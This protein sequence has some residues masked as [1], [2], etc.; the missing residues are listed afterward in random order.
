[1]RSSVRLW[2]VLV[3]VAMTVGLV[4]SVA[5][6]DDGP[7]QVIFM[8]HS[9]GAGIMYGGNVREALTDLGY[10]F[11]DHGYNDEGLTDADGNWAGLSY[12]VPG[13]NTDPDGWYEIFN[14]V[15]T[16]PPTNTLS[17][18]LTY[19]VIIFKS[20][21]PSSHIDSE[22]MFE[23]Y[24]TYYLS[25]RDVIDRYPDKLFI[26]WTT[27]PLV[28]NSTDAESAARADRWANY[29]TSDEYLD[30]HPNI[31]VFDIFHILADEDGFLAAPYRVDEWDSHPNDVAN[32]MAGTLF[33][34]FIDS[35][36]QAFA[37]G[38]PIAPVT[39]PVPAE[40]A[41]DA[42]DDTAVDEPPET[43]SMEAVEAGPLLD[44]FESGEL[45]YDWWSHADPGGTLDCVVETPGYDGFYGLALRYD[46][47][48]DVYAGCGRG[49]EGGELW[50]EAAGLQFTWRSEFPDQPFAVLLTVDSTPFEAILTTPGQ[51]W[52]HITLAWSDFERAEWADVGGPQAVEPESVVDVAFVLG[53][54]ESAQAGTVWID[55][56]SLIVEAGEGESISLRPF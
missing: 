24:Q 15:Y 4:S 35:A 19:D 12:D 5:A 46:L 34:E 2:V 36:Y 23:D 29:L 26:L 39:T 51:D 32:E 25:I 53:D 54:W 9:T 17:H 52:S 18:M 48:V 28:P 30:G 42:G 13:D 31:A 43:E 16:D 47:P 49:V 56:L 3:V 45:S 50:A 40:A 14:Q 44:D 20:C 7:V 55:A 11:W 10:A 27:P 6:Q 8:H 1:M 21:F 33:A 37:A 41:D 22:A 38:E